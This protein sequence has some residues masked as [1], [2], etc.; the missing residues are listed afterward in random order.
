M[1][2]LFLFM[3]LDLNQT[4]AYLQT[5]DNPYY[6]EACAHHEFYLSLLQSFARYHAFE[7]LDQQDEE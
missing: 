7:K 2:L 1:N 6:A 4:F 3:M 5:A